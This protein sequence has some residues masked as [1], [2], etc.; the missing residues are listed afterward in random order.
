MTDAAEP[1]PRRHAYRADLAAEKLRGR[2]EALRFVEP[3]RR[4]V[5]SPTVPVR[6]MPDPNAPLDTEALLGEVVHVYEDA[7]GW[8]WVQLERDGYV[9][10]LPSDG[11]GELGATATHRVSSPL[12]MVYSKPSAL[13]EPLM[14]APYNAQLAIAEMTGEFARLESGGYVGCRHIAPLATGERDF[15]EA[16]CRFVNAPYLYGG[17][18]AL[19][20]DCSGLVQIVLQAAGYEVPRDSDMQQAEI[21]P[22]V[23]IGADLAGLERGDLVFWTGH[24]GIMQ[25]ATMMVHASATNMCV[26]VE[27]VCDVAERS[28]KDGPAVAS[29]SRP[30]SS[31][32]LASTR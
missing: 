9:G 10:Y 21:S 13:A 15:V 2:V 27:A 24:V 31:L 4:H 25:D 20:I 16:A 17:K 26:A 11:L 22:S 23:E 18:S 28:R 19:G 30:K 7:A 14:R 3:E 5:A 1:D 6:R 29:V 32:Q 12:V 8:S